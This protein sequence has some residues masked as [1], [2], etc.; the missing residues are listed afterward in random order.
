MQRIFESQSLS[1]RRSV[2]ESFSEE[3]QTLE[4]VQTN[5]KVWRNHLVPGKTVS[6][7][8]GSRSEGRVPSGGRAITLSGVHLVSY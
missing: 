5:L 1:R 3:R 2:F 4:F 6:A 8:H 7:R